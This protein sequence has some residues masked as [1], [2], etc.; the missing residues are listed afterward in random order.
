MKL[1]VPFVQLPITFDAE[2]LAA[3]IRS[4]GDGAWHA[5][6]DDAPGNSALSLVTAG[7]DPHSAALAGP[8]RPTQWLERCPYTLQVLDTLGAT[9][10]RSRMMRLAS[11]AQVP[12]HVDTDYYW[13]Q[14]MRVHVPVVTT[15]EVRFQCGEAE[16]HM[17]AGECWI[18]D[19]WRQHRVLNDAEQA[20]IH[21]VVDTVGGGE[22]W[23]L[24]AKGRAHDGPHEGWQPR[25]VQPAPAGRGEPECEQVNIPAVMSPWELKAHIGG[26]LEDA[27]P[28]PQL[29]AVKHVAMSFMHEWRGLWFRHGE[30]E[31]GRAAYRKAVADF[32]SRVEPLARELPMRN[33]LGWLEAVLHILTFAVPDPQDSRPRTAEELRRLGDYA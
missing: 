7:G 5:R 16:V 8:M 26:L 1:Q 17:A 14:R 9:W 28:H 6:E 3:E 22:F 23:S 2:A 31:A 12:P 24:I 21:L 27:L 20:R 10:G 30:S 19:T 4:L 11:G 18:F 13:R 32:V 15:P 33:E 29:P 25:R